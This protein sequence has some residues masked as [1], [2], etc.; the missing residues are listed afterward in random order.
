[1]FEHDTA[2]IYKCFN[3]CYYVTNIIYIYLSSWCWYSQVHSRFSAGDM[4]GA[5]AASQS[6]KSWS[7]AGLVTGIVLYVI[8]V[9]CVII[10]VVFVVSVAKATIN[11][12][13]DYAGPPNYN[14]GGGNFNYWYWFFHA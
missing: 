7:I 9:I 8:G 13:I 1:M 2:C 4:A 12:G 14:Y 5:N 10:Y 11:S 3:N 6:A